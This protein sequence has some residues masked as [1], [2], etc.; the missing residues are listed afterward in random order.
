MSLTDYYTLILFSSTKISDNT[1]PISEEDADSDIQH[2]LSAFCRVN[3]MKNCKMLYLYTP[4]LLVGFFSFCFL[5]L[6]DGRFLI[7]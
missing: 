6:A 5:E 1:S 7:V 4:L 3:D 2:Y